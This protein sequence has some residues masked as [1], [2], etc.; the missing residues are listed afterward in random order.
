[1]VITIFLVLSALLG[2]VT[3][4]HVET[5][6]KVDL[7]KATENRTSQFGSGATQL[8]A[9]ESTQRIHLNITLAGEFREFRMSSLDRDRNDFVH[10]NALGLRQFTKD[11]PPGWH[12][13][14]YS[15]KEYFE[16]LRFGPS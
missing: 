7:R 15:I 6:G 16:L 5:F 12:P 11:I 13:G 4:F 1:M 10:G 14:A 9:K 8:P 3:G 2:Q